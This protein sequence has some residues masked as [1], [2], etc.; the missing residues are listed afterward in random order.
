MNK[1]TVLSILMGIFSLYTSQASTSAFSISRNKV[2]QKKAIGSEV[3]IVDNGTLI[4]YNEPTKGKPNLA[5]LPIR[6][7][8]TPDA[9]IVN[10]PTTQNSRVCTHLQ[11]LCNTN[12]SENKEA[13]IG[14]EKDISK[15]AFDFFLRSA[16]L[17]HTNG[18]SSLFL[19]SNLVQ[20]G[21]L[22]KSFWNITQFPFVIGSS[23]QE[24]FWD[25]LLAFLEQTGFCM[26]VEN[27]SSEEAILIIGKFKTMFKP[28]YK[29]K[30]PAKIKK[31]VLLDRL[32]E[33]NTSALK[34]EKAYK[35]EAALGWLL[36]HINCISL[37]IRYTICLKS[38]TEI[39]TQEA[40]RHISKINACGM[41]V[42]IEKLSL[43]ACGINIA[44]LFHSVF[45]ICKNISSLTLHSVYP[46]EEYETMRIAKSFYLC[47]NLKE[48]VLKGE[49]QSFDFA[50]LL[51]QNIPQIRKLHLVCEELKK[52]SAFWF[53]KCP[54]LTN[55]EMPANQ[56]TSRF[57]KKLL[58]T[59]PGLVKLRILCKEL[60]DST[61]EEFKR[62]AQLESLSILG[63]KQQA[64]FVRKLV[65][66]VPSLKK[67][68]IKCTS[69]DYSNIPNT[70][71]NCKGLAALTLAGAYQSKAFINEL[72]VFLPNLQSL[73]I[74]TYSLDSCLA[75]IL[76]KFK[77][78]KS[79]QLSGNYQAGFLKDFLRVPFIPK[80]LRTL[81]VKN[82]FLSDT[83]SEQDRIAI[84]KA[85]RKGVVVWVFQ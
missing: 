45:E 37:E 83:P 59:L 81:C 71:K 41:E 22:G 50:T 62:C 78:L 18:I 30:M 1:T 85:E 61:A 27:S 11:L 7:Y 64:S 57:I 13:A 25:M 67:L 36:W 79:I 28:S 42:S 26:E 29:R 3:Y 24:I 55:L 12:P 77:A 46:F 17:L 80:A 2:C 84:R 35:K 75:K 74:K 47:Q 5:F 48:L 54:H 82:Y 63:A 51:L 70:F 39:A 20:Y 72:V 21:L 53:F 9:I 56:H 16:E 40:L 58:K 66:S 32:T 44:A 31:A 69:L 49:E 15:V 14:L 10:S 8:K 4:L 65:E 73:S 43:C 6:I 60:T 76:R 19:I 52:V 68:E 34:E 23:M 38:E 33:S